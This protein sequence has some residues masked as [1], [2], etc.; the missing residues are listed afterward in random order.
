MN[1]CSVPERIFELLGQHRNSVLG[2]GEGRDQGRYPLEF[3]HRWLI[4]KSLQQK[5]PKQQRRSPI[6]EKGLP[7]WKPKPREGSCAIIET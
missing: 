3:F 7:A 5:S 4:G 1:G 6:V 2:H